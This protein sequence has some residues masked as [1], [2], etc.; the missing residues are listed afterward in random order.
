VSVFGDQGGC[1]PM[2]KPT[3]IVV[4]CA[5]LAT[6]VATEETKS[7]ANV[8]YTEPHLDYGLSEVIHPY[9]WASQMPTPYYDRKFSPYD[10]ESKLLDQFLEMQT[11]IQKDTPQAEVLVEVASS[12]EDARRR[13]FGGMLGKAA[14]GA[15]KFALKNTVAGKA[16]EF[17]GGLAGGL[18]GGGGGGGGG[19]AAGK[20][21][22]FN[23]KSQK[24]ANPKGF[25]TVMGVK[26]V[27]NPA[28][29]KTPKMKPVY[30]D[31]LKNPTDKDNTGAFK[32]WKHYRRAT[33]G[34]RRRRSPYYSHSEGFGSANPFRQLNNFFH[35]P[36]D[37]LAPRSPNNPFYAARHPEIFDVGS[38]ATVGGK[39]YGG[40]SSFRRH[41]FR[42]DRSQAFAN[43]GSGGVPSP[44]M[45]GGN[46]KFFSDGTPAHLPMNTHPGMA[47]APPTFGEP[48]PFIVGD[49][50]F[51]NFYGG[52]GDGGSSSGSE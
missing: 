14:L 16:L 38:S 49:N 12:L 11:H 35:S 3:L 10:V 43:A 34:V 17:A 5:I 45:P 46:A 23:P 9:A 47:V 42:S 39:A 15:A 26:P 36:N 4:L 31:F 18:G 44:S 50:T 7:V 52:G 28:T 19:G 37:A 8:V 6:A 2:H 40:Y 41:R 25:S 20:G 32:G 1:V 33:Y 13:G 22:L 48:S 30:S 51:H 21:G 24:T 29:F 27:N